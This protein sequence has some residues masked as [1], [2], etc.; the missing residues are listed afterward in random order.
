MRLLVTGAAGQVGRELLKLAPKH[1]AVT[2]V[3]GLTRPQLDVT[4]PGAVRQRI[5]HEAQLGKLGGGLVVVNAAAWTDV[6]GAESQ[7]EAAFAANAT[8]PALLAASCAEYDAPLLH[9]STDYVF[10]GDRTGGPPY[11]TDDAPGP[12]GAYGRTKLAGE[13]AVRALHPAGGHV[14]RTAWVYGPGR[15][16]VATMGRL[17]TERDTVE[18]VDDQQGSPTWARDLAAGLLHLGALA[19]EGRIWHLTAAGQTSWYGLARAVFA[20]LGHDPDRVRPT[21]TDAF[22][23]PAPRPAYSVLR[24]QAWVDAGLPVPRPWHEALAEAMRDGSALG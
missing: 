14:V 11:D 24:L 1:P 23:R 7:E 12:A 19:P 3:L 21:T 6:D 9:L 16:F 13:Q 4:D 22:P 8:A 10:A 15:N 20:L 18:V 5:A 2:S 17:A